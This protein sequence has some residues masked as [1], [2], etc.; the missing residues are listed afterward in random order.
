MKRVLCLAGF[1]D[2]AAM[3]ENL[4]ATGF[5]QTHEV[6]PVDLPGFAGLSAKPLRPASLHALADWVDGEVRKASADTLMAHSVASIIASLAAAKPGSP[7]DTLISL[8][9]NLTAEDAY[10]SGRAAQY[11][12]AAR[13]K[14]EFL[15]LIEERAELDPMLKRYANIAQTA[16][17]QAMWEL[18]CDAAKFSSQHHPGEVLQASGR[19]IYVYNPDNC[20]K[21]SMDWL[22][23]SALEPIR[24]DGVSHWPSIDAADQL[25]AQLL[26]AL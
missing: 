22:E 15:S 7:V 1:A 25:S 19:V 9:G 5:A 4:M 17:A 18:G 21:V 3:Y 11:D 14:S 26:Q 13:F 12:D 8:E 10:F 6:I 24:L 2:G 23:A 20:A 16:D